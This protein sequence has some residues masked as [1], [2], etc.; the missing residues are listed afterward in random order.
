MTKFKKIISSFL[1]IGLISGCLQSMAFADA[2]TVSWKE[3]RGKDGSQ[4]ADSVG[5]DPADGTFENGARAITSDTTTGNHTY[6]LGVELSEKVETGTVIVEAE[7]SDMNVPSGSDLKLF[8]LSNEANGWYAKGN[9][10]LK[11]QGSDIL[12]NSSKIKAVNGVHRLKFVAARANT[13]VEWSVDVYHFDDSEP[14]HTYTVSK[15]VLPDIKYITNNSWVA[16]GRSIALTVNKF[17]VEIIENPTLKITSATDGNVAYNAPLSVT[18]D[19]AIDDK[20]IGGI[21]LKQGAT[22]VNA[23]VALDEETKKT[24]TITPTLPLVDEQKYQI[25]IP[26][27]VKGN[28]GLSVEG[29]TAINITAVDAIYYINAGSAY[30]P[31]GEV[32]TKAHEFKDGKLNDKIH[33]SNR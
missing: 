16:S 31:T 15:A 26:T 8:D 23:N 12:I 32:T 27:T 33:R 19:S 11:I 25:V 30:N 28:N 3:T 7:F 14:I 5:Y 13:D 2:P 6:Y 24:V 29:E 21:Q 4:L 10:G 22:V 20:T 9:S 1:A 18:F 17:K